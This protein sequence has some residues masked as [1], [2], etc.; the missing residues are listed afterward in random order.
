M[1]TTVDTYLGLVVPQYQN[2]PK[3]LNWLKVPLQ[4]LQ[5]ITDCFDTF[6]AAFDIDTAV[7]DQLDILG[8]I[9]GQSRTMTFEPTGGISPILDDETYRLLLK[10]KIALNQWDGKIDSLASTWESLFPGGTIV[11]TDNQDMTMTVSVTG[12]FSSIIID[13]INNDLIVP[14]PEGVLSNASPSGETGMPYFGWDANNDYI[15]GLDRG[16]WA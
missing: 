11:V 5:S 4:M 2:S 9:A 1:T 10:A 3:F 15:S 13:L 12:T 7:G 8:E 16:I 6:D 14:R